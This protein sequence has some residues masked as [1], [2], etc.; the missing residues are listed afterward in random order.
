MNK[1][2]ITILSLVFVVVTCICFFVYQDRI[3]SFAEEEKQREEA[4][5][6]VVLG[7][8]ELSYEGSTT[9]RSHN[10]E[11][12]MARINGTIIEPGEEFSYLTALG[13]VT[14]S[15]G[16][17]KEKAFKNGEVVLGLGGGLCQVSTIL[18]NAAINAGL[19]VTARQNHTFSVEFYP[20]GLDA[21]IANPAPDLKFINNTGHPISIKGITADNKASFE[22][23][24]VSDGRTVSISDAEV[25][26]KTK[27]PPTKYI[28][29][30]DLAIGEERCEHQPQIGYT[31]KRIYNVTYADG[32]QSTQTFV[33]RYKPLPKLCYIGTAKAVLGCTATTRYSPLTGE[34][35]KS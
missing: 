18:F 4:I 3:L 20:V 8:A 22:I 28:K 14:E 25:S 32:T 10:I 33:S 7:K 15:Q 19:P 6:E 23:Y 11:L 13:P 24:G 31:A 5:Q 27:L 26:H 2:A 1:Y 9:G 17:S 16:F 21:T 12:G 30:S 34:K 29:T 35:C